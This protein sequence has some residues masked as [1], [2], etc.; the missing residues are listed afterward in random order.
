VRRPQA[1]LEREISRNYDFKKKTEKKEIVMTQDREQ[2]LAEM[3]AKMAV[4]KD[5]IDR[6]QEKAEQAEGE[7]KIQCQNHIE[8]LCSKYA[9]VE[10][11]IADLDHSSEESWWENFGA[12]VEEPYNAL[13]EAVHRL[14]PG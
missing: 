4:L 13:T 1:S 14:L 5:K 9:L 12:T 2:R 10:E 11:K 8:E 3:K 7:R 6:F